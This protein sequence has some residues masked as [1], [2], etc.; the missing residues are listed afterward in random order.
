MSQILLLTNNLLNE[1]VIEKRL[2]QLGHEVF[3]S[4][5]LIELILREKSTINFIK[6]FHCIILSETIAN[7]E[8][9]QLAKK[10]CQNSIPIVRKSDEAIDEFEM[11]EWK[12][13]GII[14]W[15]E[16]RPSVEVLR[17]K[18]YFDKKE[19]KEIFPA[20]KERRS[21]SN[22]SLN[23]SEIKLF[24]ILYQSN[25]EV[26]SRNELCLRMWNTSKNNSRMAQLSTIVNHLK[27]K[28]SSKNINGTI[29]D[30]HW[31]QGYSLSKMIYEQIDVDSKVLESIN[32]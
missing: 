10:A 11:D 16:C 26:V 20:L 28:L 14:D 17:E 1:T 30:T 29:V 18:L 23:K 12:E 4:M 15:L 21:I 31:G 3:T 9:K 27:K 13:V 22:F 6:V 19:I 5:K 32:F 24:A 8:V 2:R 7:T 25:T